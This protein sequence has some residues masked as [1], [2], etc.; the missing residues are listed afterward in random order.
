MPYMVLR[1]AGP[2]DCFRVRATAPPRRKIPNRLTLAQ[3]VWDTPPKLPRLHI[4][5]PVNHKRR[6]KCF[7][8]RKS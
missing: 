6:S 5:G 1:S 4:S 8:F 2:V 3:W 7:F